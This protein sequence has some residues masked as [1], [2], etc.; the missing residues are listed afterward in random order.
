[1]GNFTRIY[2]RLAA[3]LTVFALLMASC[4]PRDKYISFSGYAQGGTYTVKLNLNGKDGMIRKS[5]KAIKD[6]VDAL[7][8]A[9]DA[10]LSGYN[11]KSLISKFNA[12]EVIVPDEFFLDIYEKG[13]QAYQQ[14]GGA[15]DVAAAPLFD[16]WGFGFKNGQMPGDEKV[17]ETLA[18][19]GM[20]GLVSDLRKV[21]RT[22]GTLFP[23]DVL[24]APMNLTGA[25]ARNSGSQ[26][27][28]EGPGVGICPQLNYNA[29]AQGY[30]CDVIAEY[31]YSLGVKDMLV[32]IGEIFCDGHNPSGQQWGIGIDRPV[33][34]NDVSGADLQAIFRVPS[35]PHGV[36]TSG[37]YR[38][39]YVK[40]GKKYAH[41][42]D[43]RT[44]YPVSHNL[45]SA[46]IV[47]PDAT[48]ADAYAT[49]CMVIG[50][51]EAVAFIES[52][53]ELEACLVYDDGGELR[54][55]TS[56]GMSLL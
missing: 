53:P 24:A 29:I 23:A 38:K 15:L 26:L 41:T 34:G 48:M 45:L 1:M 22:D 19:C 25:N 11:K 5:P 21:L 35:G 55:W 46:T 32:D 13:Y 6:S 56:K 8:Q 51:E 31:L 14:T 17:A 33:D 3:F 10:S 27:Q 16:I 44:G 47:A 52:A 18:G 30:S 50:L 4:S 36:V 40:D 37:N 49:Y 43:P 54:T 20:K 12:G 7:L 39:F 2:L 42:I 9:I 28:G